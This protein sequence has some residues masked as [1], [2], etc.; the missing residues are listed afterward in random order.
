MKQIDCAPIKKKSNLPGGLGDAWTRLS[1]TLSGNEA[2]AQTVLITA[3]DKVLDYRFSA[4]LNVPVEGSNLLIP[5]V[6]VGPPGIW[7]IHTSPIKGVFRAREENWEE[8]NERARRYNHT[9]PN[10]VQQTAQMAA[11]VAAATAT[12]IAD[13]VKPSGETLPEKPP[14]IEPVLFFS[15]PG[16]FVD[17]VR[18]AVRI[19]LADAA[20]R[21]AA[22]L[23]NTPPSLTQGK[24]Q[25]AVAALTGSRVATVGGGV[26]GDVRDVFSFRDLPP[27]K[28][29]QMPRK[30][31]VDE[32]EPDIFR[33]VPFNRRQL[34]WLGILILINFVIL[35][36]L[37]VV[38]LL[39]MPL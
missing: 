16:T 27:E 6:V 11:A 38:V 14:V 39:N 10:L 37:A 13:M 5:V 31:V 2:D 19:V 36:A 9:R 8:L 30:V 23:A 15:D 32:S 18:P 17:T 34:I 35:T 24:A 21:F 29:A 1:Q 33:K 4:L 7:V 3:L 28:A 22:G 25:M 12:A 26:S 20:D